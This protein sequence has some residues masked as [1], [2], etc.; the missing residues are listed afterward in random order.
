VT[1]TSVHFDPYAYE[2]HEDPYPIY[3]AMRDDAP[4]YVNEEHGF[5]ALSRYADVRAAI[6]DWHTFSSTGGITLERSA[7]AVEPMLIE[8]DPPAGRRGRGLHLT[9]KGEQAIKT[10]YPLWRATQAKAESTLGSEGR[11]KL[12]ALLKQAEQLVL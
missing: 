3:Q 6:D 5:W 4:A 8:M 10:A 11:T 12:D 9:P 2:T 7:G 1:A